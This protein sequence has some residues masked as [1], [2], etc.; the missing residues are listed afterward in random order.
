MIP[1][2]YG[3]GASFCPRCAT[4]LPGPAP[5]TCTRCRYQLFV[6]AR[7]TVGLVI[8]DR[9][10]APGRLAGPDPEVGPASPATPASPV[11][12]AS[13]AGPEQPPG[14][15]RARERGLAGVRFL[16]LRRAAE[17]MAGRW[18]TPGGF[19]DGWEHPAEA[20]VREAREELGV[21]VTLGE[22]LGM[23]VGSYEF[24]DETLPVLD[25][26]FLATLD[27]PRIVLNPA[28]SA[29]LGWLPL[30]NPPPLAFATMDAAV[31]DAVGR[32]GD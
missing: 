30:V 28:E 31:R 13:P 7:P 17:P 25:T 5:T 6:N 16:A 3:P 18:E 12:S 1:R 24:Q 9:E 14:V 19:C 21:S 29:E 32:L 4:A 11:G 20:A 27:D 2:G 22:L 8:L 26:F 15:D 23:Y 10:V